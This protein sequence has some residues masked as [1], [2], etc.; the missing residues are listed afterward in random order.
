MPFIKF[1]S[2]S[3][4]FFSEQAEEGKEPPGMSYC[5]RRYSVTRKLWGIGE[6]VL[7][8][9]LFLSYFSNLGIHSVLGVWI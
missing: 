3:A 4:D 6:G 7:T 5:T 8:L 1:H 2:L 9:P